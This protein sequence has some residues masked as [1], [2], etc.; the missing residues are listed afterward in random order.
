MPSRKGRPN[1]L[2]AQLKTMILGALSDV[3][4]QRYL[5]TQAVA[6]PVA[7]MALLGK[8]LPATLLDAANDPSAVKFEVTVSVRRAQAV[9]EIEAAF[10]DITA[11]PLIEFEEQ[12]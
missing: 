7:F 4:G 8:V 2:G 1:K 12:G 3:G 11:Q 10:T 5:A 9:T 6:E